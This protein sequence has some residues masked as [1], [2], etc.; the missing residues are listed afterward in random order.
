MPATSLHPK[1]R[2]RRPTPSSLDDLLCPVWHLPPAGSEAGLGA[3]P[4]GARLRGE[5]IGP[6]E[7]G[8]QAPPLHPLGASAIH[9]ASGSPPLA[10]EI[11]GPG[12]WL[13]GTASGTDT[14]KEAKA[15]TPMR[16]AVATRARPRS[17]G[18]G[19][20]SDSRARLTGA[21]RGGGA[22]R[23]RGWVGGRWYPG[24]IGSGRTRRPL[25]GWGRLLWGHRWADTALGSACRN[26]SATR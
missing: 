14:A 5:V 21:V 12:F 26:P 25:R 15:R 18:F 6:A 2:R 13:I 4:V 3:P 11:R 22:G 9:A 23:R 16:K 10:P 7:S 19:E 24:G 17:W 20:P 8:D 1:G